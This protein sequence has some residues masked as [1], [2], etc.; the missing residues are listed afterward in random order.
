MADINECVDPSPCPHGRCVNTL[1][2]YKCVSCG[3]GYRPR[4]GRCVGED[5]GQSLG[6]SLAPH[7]S[8]LC[9]TQKEQGHGQHAP[10]TG[11]Q[12]AWPGH[13][14]LAIWV[15]EVA[16][17]TL[18]FFH[19]AL[20]CVT[21]MWTSVLQRGPVLTGSVSTWMAPSAVP[22]TGA[23]MWHLIRRAAKVLGS[24][25]TLCSV[26]HLV[27]RFL[28]ALPHSTW[29]CLSPGHH[30]GWFPQHSCP[31]SWFLRVLHTHPALPCMLAQTSMSALPRMP[32]PLDSAS[33]P[34][35]PTPA[36]LVMLATLSPEMAAC[37][38][39]SLSQ[40][41]GVEGRDI[42]IAWLLVVPRDFPSLRILLQF[43]S[44]LISR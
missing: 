42:A 33:T 30:V 1:G 2:S 26:T 14:A 40:D 4:N 11:S 9:K 20:C 5:R 36:R 25:E 28:W 39:V 6:S 34:R 35:A 32:V 8:A 17:S 38:K 3:D 44:S 10:P 43:F 24:H 31:W 7:G 37:V 18:S 41:Q 22:A 13:S 19:I 23:T 21:Q 16:L 12:P 15:A 27:Q 29:P